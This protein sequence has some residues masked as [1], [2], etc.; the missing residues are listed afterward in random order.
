M[1]EIIEDLGIDQD[2]EVIEI[3][4]SYEDGG[5]TYYD[6]VEALKKLGIEF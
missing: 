4:E 6:Y 2:D 1:N 3:V 5:M